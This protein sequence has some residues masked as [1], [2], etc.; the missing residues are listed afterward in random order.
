MN[1]DEVKAYCASFPGVMMKESGAPSNIMIFYVGDKKFAYFKT[2]DPEKWRFSFRTTSERFLELTDQSGVKPA[3]YM[4]R[5]HWVTIVSV[6]RFNEHYLIDL[7]EWS[8]QKALSSL[9]KKIQA[10]IGYL[11]AEKLDS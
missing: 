3:R 6:E 1:V 5:F 8:Y 9:P 4:Q 2:S 7:I 11:S 10:D